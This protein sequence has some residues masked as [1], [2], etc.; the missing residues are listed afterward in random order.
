M[1]GTPFRM[2]KFKTMRTAL[3]SDGN[4]LPGSGC[5]TKFGTLFRATRLDELSEPWK[6][7]RSEMSL[8]GPRP[9]LMEILDFY[10]PEQARRREA[11]PRVKGWAQVNH[12]LL[13]VS[14]VKRH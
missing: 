8:V 5:V 9:L 10:P 2:I 6:V 3:G 4:P 7:L 13:P 1:Q 12:Y 11:R 14:W